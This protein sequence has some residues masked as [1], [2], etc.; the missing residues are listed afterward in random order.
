MFQKLGVL[1]SEVFE[2]PLSAYSKLVIDGKEHFD[3]S[4]TGGDGGG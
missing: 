1:F 2:G 4:S 3:A